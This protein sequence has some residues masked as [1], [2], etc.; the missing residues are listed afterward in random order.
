MGDIDEGKGQALCDELQGNAG[1]LDI[2]FYHFV[3]TDLSDLAQ[4][5][6]LFDFTEDKFGGIDIVVVSERVGRAS[7]LG[8]GLILYE[9]RYIRRLDAR[10]NNG[11]WSQ[12]S[13]TRVS[14]QC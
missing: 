8:W 6:R 3:K 12:A 11:G 10:Q 4:V 5:K 1:E 13:W 2:D 7:W 9:P 14:N